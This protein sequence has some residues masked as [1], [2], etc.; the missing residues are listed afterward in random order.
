MSRAYWPT[1]TLWLVFGSLSFNN[2]WRLFHC[3]LCTL[4]LLIS[5]MLHFVRAWQHSS[6]PVADSGHCS[7][8]LQFKVLVTSWWVPCLIGTLNRLKLLFL[9]QLWDRFLRLLECWQVT[10]WS[11]FACYCT[12]NWPFFSYQVQL[13]ERC[14]LYFSLNADSKGWH[15]WLKSPVA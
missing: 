1:Q 11:G 9:M 2:S 12:W 14:R 8:S 5:L 13:D 7:V 4:H 6:L 3:S 15:Q 10:C